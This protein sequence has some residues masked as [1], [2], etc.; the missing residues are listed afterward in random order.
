MDSINKASPLT[1]ELLTIIETEGLDGLSETFHRNSIAEGGEGE[2]EEA[3]LPF[4]SWLESKTK[5]K[6]KG[7]EKKEGSLNTR[8]S[9][10]ILTMSNA[11]WDRRQR[12]QSLAELT[13]FPGI[14]P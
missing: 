8:C 7:R 4:S 14:R 3:K 11:Q 10:S 5:E 9:A 1:P 6:I 12:Y 2:G 13:R